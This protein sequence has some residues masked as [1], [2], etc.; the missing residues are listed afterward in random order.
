MS[1]TDKLNATIARV[2]TLYEARGWGVPPRRKAV[3]VRCNVVT[4]ARVGGA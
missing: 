3:V 4:V 1:S 2:R